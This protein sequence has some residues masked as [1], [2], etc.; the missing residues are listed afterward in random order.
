MGL[1][2]AF[3]AWEKDDGFGTEL[4]NDLA[5]R[6]AGRARYSAVIHY[7]NGANVQLWTVGRDG[8]KDRR[9]LGAIGHSVGGVFDVAAGK[10]LA[11]GSKDGG[12]D[13]E[14]GVG[15]VGILHC[16]FC[17]VDQLGTIGGLLFCHRL[18]WWPLVIRT[19]G[20]SA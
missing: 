11:G 18:V 12:P 4:V 10:D 8:G 13:A 6:A 20:G 2:P 9:T 3:C 5:A 1:L 17:G 14:F 7:C 19:Y 15:C 16:C